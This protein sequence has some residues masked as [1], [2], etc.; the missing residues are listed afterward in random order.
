MWAVDGAAEDGVVGR[1][2]LVHR[3]PRS[4]SRL[5]LDPQRSGDFVRRDVWGVPP[6]E[7]AQHAGLGLRVDPTA[8]GA[9]QSA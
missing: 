2:A 5:H 9:Y 6:D 7:E 1:L 3:K 4:R 8:E